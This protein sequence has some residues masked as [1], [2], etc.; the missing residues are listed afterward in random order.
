MANEYKALT[1]VMVG[2]DKIAPGDSVSHNDLLAAGQSDED[3]TQL[4]K[5][6]VISEDQDAEIHEAHREAARPPL[7]NNGQGDKKHIH[8]AEE[9]KG[10]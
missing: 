8:A 5:S 1:Y 3:V 7:E 6:G 4:L 2:D 10:E 9:G